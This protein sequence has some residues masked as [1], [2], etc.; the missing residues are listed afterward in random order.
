MIERGRSRGLALHGPRP[1]RVLCGSGRLETQKL[2]DRVTEKGGG[3][4]LYQTGVLAEAEKAHYRQIDALKGIAIFLVILGHSIIR[5]PIDLLQ[6][7]ACLFLF[8]WLSSVHM[9]LF[10]AIS[11]FCFRCPGNYREYLGKK[12]RRMLVPYLVFN[13][14]DMVPRSLFRSLVNRPRE[15]GGSVREMIF[16]GGE[17]WFLYT[18]FLIFLIF[19]FLYRT[20]RGK[21]C[22]MAGLLVL[23]LAAGYYLPYIPLFTLDRVIRYLFWFSLGVMV[24]EAFGGRIFDLKIPG[25]ARAALIALLLPLWVAVLQSWL[26][27]WDVLCALIGITALWLAAQ[28]GPVITIFERFGRYSLQLYLFNGFFLVASRTVIVSVLGVREPAVIILFN[29]VV[30]LLG[31]YLVIKYL[32]ERIGPVRMLMGMR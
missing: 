19:P 26:L 2:V 9:E 22:L 6:D 28:F 23:L 18:L 13:L 10:F 17:Y 27:G 5:Y 29:L 25:P 3:R 14:L 4:L 20:V 21:R 11:G 15:I 1:Y 8:E 7:R 12:A 16:Y 31:S 30:D 24:K 32:C